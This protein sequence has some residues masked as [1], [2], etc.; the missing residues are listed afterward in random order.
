MNVLHFKTPLIFGACLELLLLFGTANVL[1]CKTPF[2]FIPLIFG[3]CVD[4]V[5]HLAFWHAAL[6][7]TS[8]IWRLCWT[9]SLIWHC[10]WA[11]L[12]H[13]S[14]I[15]CWTTFWIDNVDVLNCI[16]P[17]IFGACVQLCLSFSTADVLHIENLLY[18]ALVLN[19]VFDSALPMS[20]IAKD[21]LYFALVVNCHFCL[22]LPMCCIAKTLIFGACLFWTTSFI[23]HCSWAALR[24]TFFIWCF[25]SITSFVCHLWC[26]AMKN[27]LCLALVL[28]Y[29]F[30]L[31][32]SMCWLVKYLFYFALVLICN[33]YFAL[34]MCA[35]MPR[36]CFT[37]Y[38]CFGYLLSAVRCV[39]SSSIFMLHAWTRFGTGS[40]LLESTPAGFCGF[41][42]DPDP[43]S[44]ICEEPDPDPESH[45]NFGI[46][47]SLCGHF[48]GKNM[49][50]LR[51]EWWL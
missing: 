2:I 31:S 38:L 32:L 30:Y 25:G 35:A 42:S 36:K 49:D 9:W 4:Y 44:K 7:S 47:R 27:V 48:S 6:Q 33:I 3:A 8:Y 18:L 13:T 1:C 14:Y 45:F 20:C 28:Q 16:K 12:Q 51:L 40:G 26:G 15:W 37:F 10:W 43:E 50:K 23:P 34:C 11:V 39:H 22:A 29:L 24:N 41:C 5:F 19:L 21:L 17:L 46:G